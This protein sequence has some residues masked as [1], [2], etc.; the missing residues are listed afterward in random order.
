MSVIGRG[1]LA[2]LV[3]ASLNVQAARAQGADDPSKDT[4]GRLLHASKCV[5]SFGFGSGCDKDAPAPKAP[6]SG[7]HSASKG[8]DSAPTTKV[9]DDTSTRGRLFHASK[10][11]VSFGFS[12]GCDKDA[13]D[14]SAAGAG[15][16]AE[17]AVAKEPD[18]STRGQL[19]HASKCV[20]SFG[21]AGDCD[22][23]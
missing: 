10:C 17:A 16:R 6:K 4:K 8:A 1:V 14:G 2:G 5:M 23:K 9:A 11:V 13:P 3:C 15:R 22:K 18:T 19:F 7:D 21:F 12:G 20:I